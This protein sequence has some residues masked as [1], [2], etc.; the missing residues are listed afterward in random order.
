MTPRPRRRAHAWRRRLSAQAHGAPQCPLHASGGVRLHLLVEHGGRNH[1]LHL[2]VEPLTGPVSVERLERKLSSVLDH[3]LV[4]K[5]V[6]KEHQE[7]PHSALVLHEIK[8]QRQQMFAT[9]LVLNQL[10]QQGHERGQRLRVFRDSLNG[11]HYVLHVMVENLLANHRR[12]VCDPPV[13]QLPG[14]ERED[15]KHG[16]DAPC[17]LCEDIPASHAHFAQPR[18]PVLKP[19]LEGHESP[20]QLLG[21]LGPPQSLRCLVRLVVSVDKSLVVL[22]RLLHAH[23]GLVDPLQARGE[24]LGARP[25]SSA[26]AVVAKATS[27]QAVRAQLQLQLTAET[28]ASSTSP[29]R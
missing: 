21:R 16:Q 19:L 20:V 5:Q 24:V 26:E 8:H 29:H 1:C 18:D 23:Q 11:V 15:Q 17:P 27:P 6:L 28:M 13:D 12:L 10:G 7:C 9:G 14:Q 25:S 22:Q 3:G 4:L 2:R